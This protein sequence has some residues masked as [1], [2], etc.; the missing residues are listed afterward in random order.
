MSKENNKIEILL[1]EIKGDVQL[2]KSG[3]QKNHDLIQKNGIKI[4]Q[5]ASDVKAVAEG[6]GVIRKEI[7]QMEGRLAEKIEENNSAIKF[8]TNKVSHIDKKLDEHI[9]QPAHV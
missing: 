6:H 4:E 3:Q 1:G 9:H 7:Q 2:L 8:V 5:V